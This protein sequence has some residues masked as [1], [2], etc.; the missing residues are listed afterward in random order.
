MSIT[1]LTPHTVTIIRSIPDPQGPPDARINMTLTYEPDR[2]R[3]LPRATEG[4]TSA[5]MTLTE[6]GDGQAEYSTCGSLMRL[7]GADPAD[8]RIMSIPEVTTGY[9]GVEGLPEIPVG[10]A[11]FGLEHFYIVSIVTVLGALVAG[12]PIAHLLVPTGQIRDESGRIIG[13]AGLAWAP[14]VVAGV[15][16]ASRKHKHMGELVADAMRDP[17]INVASAT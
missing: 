4:Q 12:R 15:V 8:K 13:A 7:L 6:T 5:P 16:D 14:Y 3:P 17:A 2:S 1:N 11:A 10:E 9:T